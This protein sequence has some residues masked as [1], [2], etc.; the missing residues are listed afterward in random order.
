VIKVIIEPTGKPGSRGQRYQ[1]TYEGEVIA[2]SIA[3]EYDAC[4]ALL[5]RG[6]T[7]RMLTLDRSGAPRMSF[8]IEKGATLTISEGNGRLTVQRWY[9]FA[10]IGDQADDER[11]PTSRA[12]DEKGPSS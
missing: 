12:R 11:A 3:A 2:A 9:P 1:V 7:G 8:D 6:I 10:G 4:R 5:A